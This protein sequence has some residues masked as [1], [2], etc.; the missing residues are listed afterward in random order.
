[1]DSIK[2][3]FYG[4]IIVLSIVGAATLVILIFWISKC[5]R[6][7]FKSKNKKEE[8]SPKDKKDKK[9]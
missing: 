3:Y 4:F 2:I 5:K 6:T 9:H 8:E 1:M 7:W